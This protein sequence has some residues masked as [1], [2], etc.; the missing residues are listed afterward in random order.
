[1]HQLAGISSSNANKM[2]GLPDTGYSSAISSEQEQCLISVG[3]DLTES[4]VDNA[5]D[6][7]HPRVRSCVCQN[8]M[9]QVCQIYFRHKIPTF[10]KMG[11]LTQN[12]LMF[13]PLCISFY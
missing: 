13:F 1:M 9:T 6:Q 11:R 8:T 10:I 7:W 3:I 2:L 5:S 12:L 4:V